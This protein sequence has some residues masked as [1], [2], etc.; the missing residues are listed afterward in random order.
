MRT[1]VAAIICF[2]IA[3]PLIA[4]YAA[5]DLTRQ[6][7]I[8]VVVELGT[9]D[10]EMRFVPDQLEFETG[11]LYKLVLVNPSPHKHYFTSPTL[12][13]KVFT[14]KVDVRYDG[15]RIAE[16]RGNIAEIEVFPGGQSEWWFVPVSTGTFS[17]LHCHVKEDGGPSHQDM[18][19]VG[20][21]R[22][23]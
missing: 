10:G 8:E 6:K 4:A 11:K 21:I 22:I 13:S 14:R 15:K 18:G 19:M 5:G 17:D 9:K 7:P 20:T 3:S 2:V 1:A 12:A 16:I 23:R